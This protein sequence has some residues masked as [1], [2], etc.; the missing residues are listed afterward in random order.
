MTDQP[1]PR[2]VGGQA[3][4]EGVMMRGESAWAVAVR[5]PGGGID[6]EVHDVQQLNRLLAALRALE[7]VNS[8]ER[9]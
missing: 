8:A 2:S 5:N 9:V 3:V 6:V 7:T 1:E 4:M